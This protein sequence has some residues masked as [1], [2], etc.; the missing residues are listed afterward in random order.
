M[1]LY[2][3]L[4]SVDD[5]NKQ[6]LDRDCKCLDVHYNIYVIIFVSLLNIC[7]SNYPQT[8]GE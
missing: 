8:L 3:C 4:I 1:Y 2:Y 7:V 6:I 5:W